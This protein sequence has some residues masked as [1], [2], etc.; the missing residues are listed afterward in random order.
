M[1]RGGGRLDGAPGGPPRPPARGA[2]Q[3]GARRAALPLHRGVRARRG[4][5]AL[6]DPRGRRHTGGRVN[7]AKLV[8]GHRIVV[9]AGS[10]G[11]GKTTVAA[12]VAL[13]GALVGRRT[14]VITIDPAR[15]LASSMGLGTLAE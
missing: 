8:E 5:G 2:R 7:L 1:R 12:S 3:R 11:V 4:R 14:V 9:A 13:W 10:G 6:G 15:R